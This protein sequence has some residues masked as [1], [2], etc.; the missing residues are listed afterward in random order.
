[1]FRQGIQP[2]VT[3]GCPADVPCLTEDHAYTGHRGWGSLFEILCLEKHRHRIA[4]FDD[5][6]TVQTEFL[7]VEEE[8]GVCV[9]G[10]IDRGVSGWCDDRVV[11]GVM[12]GW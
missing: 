1:M 12:T 5:L 11:G 8:D 9:V 6:A 4:H 2:D 7:V 10:C 3:Y